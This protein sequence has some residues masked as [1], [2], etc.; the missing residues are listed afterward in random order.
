MAPRLLVFVPGVRPLFLNWGAVPLQVT[1]ILE[2]WNNGKMD[3][4]LSTGLQGH[5][6][7]AGSRPIWFA[8]EAGTVGDNIN[9]SNKKMYQPIFLN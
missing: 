8:E 7:G 6:F 4:G 3:L 5:G 1:G 2:C 9:N